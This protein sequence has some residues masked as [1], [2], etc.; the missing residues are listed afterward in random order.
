MVPRSSGLVSSADAWPHVDA[1]QVWYRID[2]D[3]VAE[4]IDDYELWKDAP[5]YHA[6]DWHRVIDLLDGVLQRHCRDGV[7]DDLAQLLDP[8]MST[9]RR[10][11]DEA[12]DALISWPIGISRWQLQDG[13]HR[14][15][16]MR[17]QGVRFVPG[18]C[19]RSDVGSSVDRAQVY[20]VQDA[21]RGRFRSGNCP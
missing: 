7:V 19:M 21:G 10:P 18:C 17:A 5:W 16:A 15:V 6:V 3:Q 11:D 13:G 9:L 20:P 4:L 12:V 1:E 2:L 8:A 14:A